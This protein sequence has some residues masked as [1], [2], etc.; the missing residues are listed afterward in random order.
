MCGIAGM[1]SAG[2]ETPPRALV[3]RMCD[4][5]RHRGP[6]GEGIF[7][8]HGIGLGMRRLAIIDLTT[9]DQPVTNADG[10]IKAVFNGEIYNYRELRAGLEQRGHVF[11]SQG[12]SE[13]IPHLYERHGID[14]LERL[15]GMFAIALWDAAK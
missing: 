15:N 13:V 11:R 2:D 14:F 3:Q 4:A 1:V 6:A 5:I 9:G 10:R 7:V 8:D 12:D